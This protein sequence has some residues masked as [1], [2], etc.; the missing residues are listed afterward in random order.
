MEFWQGRPSRLH[1]RIAYTFDDESE[2]WTKSRLA[3]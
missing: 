3:P 1:D 2:I